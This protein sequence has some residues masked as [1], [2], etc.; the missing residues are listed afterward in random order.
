M[1]WEDRGIHVERWCGVDI[2]HYSSRVSP[3]RTIF[4]VIFVRIHVENILRM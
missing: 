4:E 2:V 1:H 3:I